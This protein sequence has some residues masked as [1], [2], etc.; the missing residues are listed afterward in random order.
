[1]PHYGQP[2][3]LHYRLQCD[4]VGGGAPVTLLHGVG[5]SLEVWDG[6]ARNLCGCATLRVDLR[7]HGRSDKP[8]GPYQLDDFVRD[9][10]G[11]YEHLGIEQSHLVGFSLGGIIAQAFALD[12]PEKVSRLVL[13]SAVAGRTPAE[14]A[15]VRERA[16]AVMEAGAKQHARNSTDRWFTAAFRKSHPEIIARHLRRFTANDPA[17]YS[18]AYRVLAESD[19]SGRLAEISRPTLII[20]GER[21]IGSTPRMAELMRQKIPHSELHILPG[22]KHALLLEAPDQIANLIRQ[23]ITPDSTRGRAVGD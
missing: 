15:R 8:P 1:M 16:R 22:L 3:S 18:A 6:V 5:S 11:L 10:A 9:L 21:D 14:K 13:I 12:H 20:T 7:G 23:F 2:V 4:G 17:A 19:L